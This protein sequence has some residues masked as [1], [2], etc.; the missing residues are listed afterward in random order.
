MA[1]LT[2]VTGMKVT[3]STCFHIAALSG[4]ILFCPSIVLAQQAGRSGAAAGA[5]AKKEIAAATVQKVSFKRMPLT[6]SRMVRAEVSVTAL[7]NAKLIEDKAAIVPNPEWVDKIKVTVTLAYLTKQGKAPKPRGTTA[8][9]SGAEALEGKYVFYRA[10]STIMTLQRNKHGSVFFYLPGELIERDGLASQP[11]EY[12]VELEVD[13]NPS[14]LTKTACS[15][16]LQSSNSAAAI[17]LF[18][19]L[20][21][22][23]ST[24]TAGMLRTQPQVAGIVTDPEWTR[25]PTLLREDSTRQ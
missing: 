23:Q 20:A 3:P 7:A 21:D 9:A 8:A 5:S 24:E 13:G 16:G 17:E 18:K 6:N 12:L 25:S 22:R 10:A 15:A 4:L 1:A 14:P 2:R 11:N 19:S